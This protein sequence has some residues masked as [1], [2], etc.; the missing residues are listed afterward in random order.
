[1]KATQRKTNTVQTKKAQ[2]K[3]KRVLNLKSR[4]KTGVKAGPTMAGEAAEY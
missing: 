4:L 3:S 1:M 2:T